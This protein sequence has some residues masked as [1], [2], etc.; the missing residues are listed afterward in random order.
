MIRRG[1]FLTRRAAKNFH[2]LQASPTEEKNDEA[3]AIAAKA[4]IHGDS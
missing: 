3:P 1:R 4:G 2:E